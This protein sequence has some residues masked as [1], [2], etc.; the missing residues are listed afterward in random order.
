MSTLPTQQG[1]SSAV[2]EPDERR[3][4]P[5]ARVALVVAAVAAFALV[6]GGCS[7]D[8]PTEDVKVVDLGKDEVGRCLLVGPEIDE[9]VATLP[10]IDC[11]EEH[12]HEIFASLTMSDEDFDVYPGTDALEVVA[13]RECLTAFDTY[14]GIS[15]FDSELFYSWLVPTLD[16]W[17]KSGDR[18]VLCVAGN[19]DSALLPPGS[20]KGTKR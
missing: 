11:S 6:G 19:H 12:S 4:P 3:R 8:D 9:Q 17:T 7:D 2:G 18:V 14:V 15:P 5:A 16:S 10:L 13:E 20:I 1:R